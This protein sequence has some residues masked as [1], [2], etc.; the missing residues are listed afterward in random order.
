MNARGI[1]TAACPSC[2]WTF[3]RVAVHFDPDTYEIA[4]YA[5]DAECDDCGALV[6]APTPIDHPADPDY[7]DPLSV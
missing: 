4:F 5:L 1:P 6:T 7:V 2:G 3:F